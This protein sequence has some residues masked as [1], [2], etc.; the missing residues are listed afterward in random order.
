MLICFL[1]SLKHNIK[2]AGFWFDRQIYHVMEASGM[3]VDYRY[4]YLK[5]AF[6]SV[7]AQGGVLIELSGSRTGECNWFTKEHSPIVLLSL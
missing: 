7:V 3:V 5:A 1:G 4:F 6:A 2:L